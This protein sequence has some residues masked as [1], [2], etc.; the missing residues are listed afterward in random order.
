MTPLKRLGWIGAGYGAAAAV[1]V[2]VLT[3]RY[4]F[5]DP[6]DV[7]AMSGMFAGGDAIG[8]VLI[9]G[10][11]GLVPTFFLLRLATETHPR[12]LA[13]ALLTLSATAP[14]SLWLLSVLSSGSLPRQGTLNDLLGLAMVFLIGPRVVA[15]P[16]VFIIL[17]LALLMAREKRTRVW[18]ACG[19]V[20]EAVP[21]ILL[22]I[23]F[24]L[25]TPQR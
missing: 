20:L 23:H 9:A 25:T 3:A 17:A 4:W 21:L 1:A 15:I 18:L 5:I 2:F 22:V 13:A 14:L 7:S 10:A 6:A 11:L 12:A 24:A 8:F 16:V 19:L